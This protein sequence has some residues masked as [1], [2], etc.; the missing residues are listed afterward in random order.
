MAPVMRTGTIYAAGQLPFDD[1]HAIDL[2]RIAV[3]AA[4]ANAIALAFDQH[5]QGLAHKAWFISSE[6]PAC[7]SISRS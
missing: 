6:I 2:G 4:R 7:S 3:G 1:D 5:V